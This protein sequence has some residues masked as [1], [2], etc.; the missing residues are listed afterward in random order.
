MPAVPA[1]AAPADVPGPVNTPLPAQAAGEDEAV[2][3]GTDQGHVPPVLR[4]LRKCQDCGFPISAGR[5]LC[6][7]CEDKKW[8]EQLWPQRPARKPPAGVVAVSDATMTGPAPAAAASMAKTKA[9]APDAGDVQ[10]EPGLAS[11]RV[12]VQDENSDGLELIL[13]GCVEPSRT[14]FS[15]HRYAVLASLAI[16]IVVTVFLL[17]R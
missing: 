13:S 15:A 1:V 9:P 6:L 4:R 8:R 12:D 10:S 5:V 17:V 14:W 16:G 2:S 7:E 11:T 3:S